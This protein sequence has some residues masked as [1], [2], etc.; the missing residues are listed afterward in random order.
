[1]GEK[2]KNIIND[3]ELGGLISEQA[4]NYVSKLDKEKIRLSWIKS[5]EST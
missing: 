5:I 1:M 4:Y 2:V 3:K